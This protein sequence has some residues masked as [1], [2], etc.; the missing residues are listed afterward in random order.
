M[1][2]GYQ[3]EDF[4]RKGFTEF[5]SDGLRL[6]IDKASEL[7]EFLNSHERFEKI[8]CLTK[9]RRFVFIKTRVGWFYWEMIKRPIKK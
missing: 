8:S 7:Q 9:T 5:V 6:T 4:V 2:I 3:A 1:N